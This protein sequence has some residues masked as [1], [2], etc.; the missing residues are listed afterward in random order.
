VVRLEP[1]AEGGPLR[2]AMVIEKPGGGALSE[3]LH[4]GS[5]PYV[6]PSQAMVRVMDLDS[7]QERDLFRLPWVPNWQVTP[8]PQCA[9]PT[10]TAVSLESYNWCPTVVAPS[11]VEL[12]KESALDCFSWSP[13]G[14]WLSFVSPYGE[15]FLVEAS[16]A[17]D[18]LALYR[19][20]GELYAYL[21]VG[22]GTYFHG[23]VTCAAWL[24]ADRL[25]FLGFTGGLPEEVSPGEGDFPSDTTFLA[26]L[27]EGGW[28]ITSQVERPL[29]DLRLSPDGSRAVF[30]EFVQDGKP[31]LFIGEPFFAPEQVA[32]RQL[33]QG[34]FPPSVRAYF[35][36]PDGEKLIVP[37][38]SGGQPG[39][40]VID[41]NSLE[42][43]SFDGRLASWGVSEYPGW[44]DSLFWPEQ[45]AV[46]E[47]APFA[48]G[49]IGQEGGKLY[50]GIGDLESGQLTR[51][52]IDLG[53]WRPSQFPPPLAFLTWLP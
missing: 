30:Y 16:G 4:Q 3:G 15:L 12:A 23:E 40:T 34:G 11:A 39:L 49:F 48:L 2:L 29:W 22:K 46:G 52:P 5:L 13:D 10:P 6:D 47:A 20:P 8:D 36:S 27:L 53:G 17:S 51:Y 31:A 1:A 32:G 24:A 21:G 26:Q 37:T 35:F 41:L 45:G 38:M 25:A 14:R 44:A 43:E 42:S 7:G 19:A 33:Y 18:P 28:A 50:L 9:G